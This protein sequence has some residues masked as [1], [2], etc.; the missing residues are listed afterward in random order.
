M[1][2][3]KDQITEKREELCKVLV[4]MNRQK[5]K[6]DNIKK[7]LANDFEKNE[8]AYRDGVVTAA[9]VL[10]RKPRFNG[11]KSSFPAAG[12]K[13]RFKQRGRAVKR[14]SGV[15][16]ACTKRAP[17]ATNN[18]ETARISVSGDCPRLRRRKTRRDA[19]QGRRW[20]RASRGSA[21]PA[22]RPSRQDRTGRRGDPYGKSKGSDD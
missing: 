22:L 16:A 10:Y 21:C 5:A 2:L 13:G 17:R 12:A 11:W 19:A 18:R 14:G 6:A 4:A 15:L 8:K 1:K 7:D 9:G 20:R 3:T